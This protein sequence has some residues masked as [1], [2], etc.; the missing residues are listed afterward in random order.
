[1]NL[2]HLGQGTQ[3]SRADKKGPGDADNEDSPD[4]FS[5]MKSGLGLKNIISEESKQT[6]KIVI[7]NS[8][9]T[10]D[11]KT[12][13]LNEDS[14]EYDQ[15]QETPKIKPFGSSFKDGDSSDLNDSFSTDKKKSK[16]QKP[17]IPQLSFPA[18]DSKDAGDLDSEADAA[19]HSDSMDLDS[20]E[21]S[22]DN[23]TQ[24]VM[25][26]TNK[27]KK[28]SMI[29]LNKNRAFG[30]SRVLMNSQMKNEKRMSNISYGFNSSMRMIQKNDLDRN[31]MTERPRMREIRGP[32][33][34]LPIRKEIQQ[35]LGNSYARVGSGSNSTLRYN[36]NLRASMPVKMPNFGEEKRISQ[37]LITEKRELEMVLD[38]VEKIR[39]EVKLLFVKGA[40][41]LGRVEDGFLK[42]NGSVEK[43]FLSWAET[44]DKGV[45]EQFGMKELTVIPKVEIER[46]LENTSKNQNDKVMV[47]AELKAKKK[48]F[49]YYEKKVKDLESKNNRLTFNN[50]QLKK[51]IESLSRKVT[52]LENKCE[53]EAELDRRANQ[54]ELKS[55]RL[56]LN[57]SEL[58]EKQLKDEQLKL[59]NKNFQLLRRKDNL[60]GNL[61]KDLN[62]T[63][64]EMEKLKGKIK[65]IYSKGSEGIKE[66][67]AEE[68]E[69]ENKD[70]IALQKEEIGGLKKQIRKQENDIEN[71]SMKIAEMK[72]ENEGEQNKY[73]DEIKELDS[74]IEEMEEANTE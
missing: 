3:G 63:T 53:K 37:L 61:R 28:I 51:Q 42:L 73:L 14:K 33:E 46:L 41:L 7:T 19:S 13:D 70:L 50:S 20:Q 31:Y 15:L 55:L 72:I 22:L 24:E 16:P 74:K 34:E 44:E 45:F 27:G 66:E 64:D 35:I 48:R 65:S 1:M 6:E 60:I 30:Q 17:Q 71:L 62:L 25:D 69:K 12:P 47:S 8:E 26:F 49:E 57:Q 38:Q 39:E 40:S 68:Q 54:M 18:P 59:E 9:K 5:Y 67:G 58:R 36:K 4:A 21:E 52:V 29:S 32:F 2:K 11:N 56:K 43:L 23:C 10:I